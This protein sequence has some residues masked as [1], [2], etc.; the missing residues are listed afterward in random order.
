MEFRGRDLIGTG[1]NQ[2][3]QYLLDL[4]EFTYHDRQ[5]DSGN[6]TDGPTF[7][8]REAVLLRERNFR[9]S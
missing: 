1:I 6:V 4:I 3:G 5:S 7:V 8:I 9:E 2:A